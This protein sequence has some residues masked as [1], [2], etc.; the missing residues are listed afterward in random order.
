MAAIAFFATYWDLN[1]KLDNNANTDSESSLSKMI[2][3][4]Q[5]WVLQS[6]KSFEC[7]CRLKLLF[8]RLELT[9]NN[10]QLEAA[11]Y[12]IWLKI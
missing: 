2:M 11:D 8:S 5:S 3:L 4:K 10:R 1:D 6:T 12:S 7:Q 9:A